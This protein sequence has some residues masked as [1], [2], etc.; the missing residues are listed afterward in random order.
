MHDGETPHP[1]EIMACTPQVWQQKGI[2]E[3]IFIQ[4]PVTYNHMKLPLSF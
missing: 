2:R 1:Q 4:F 3:N